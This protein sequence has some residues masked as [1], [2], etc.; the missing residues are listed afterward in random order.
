MKNKL[1]IKEMKTLVEQGHLEYFID[2]S[3]KLENRRQ[4]YES[5]RY[6]LL[7]FQKGNKYALKLLCELCNSGNLDK[8]LSKEEQFNWYLRS[9]HEN[10]VDYITYILAQ[11]YREGIG[12]KIDLDKYIFYLNLCHEDGSITATIELA[13][14]YENGFAVEQNYEKAYKLYTSCFDEHFKRDP[15]SL[16]KEAYYRYHE[17]G[18]AIKDLNIIKDILIRSGMNNSKSR[19]LY[20]EIFGEDYCE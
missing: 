19:E 13:L 9:Y 16:Y 2:L 1:T 12:T 17:F 5:Y 7:A 4:Y 10:G 3:N 20:K 11:C 18:G 8:Y 14:C 6:L 15:I